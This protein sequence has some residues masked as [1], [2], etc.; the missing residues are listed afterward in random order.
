M[1]KTKPYMNG[2]NRNSR[3]I[4]VYLVYDGT[5]IFV[6]RNTDEYRV[7]GFMAFADIL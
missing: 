3:G 1:N 7:T 4:D 5:S 2:G 6:A